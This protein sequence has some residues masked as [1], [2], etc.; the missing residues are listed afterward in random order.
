MYYSQKQQQSNA[1]TSGGRDTD[2]HE[3]HNQ[4]VKFITGF[5]NLVIR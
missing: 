2:L 5:K 3:T 4:R 1:A